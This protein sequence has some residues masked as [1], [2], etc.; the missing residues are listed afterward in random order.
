MHAKVCF[1]TTNFYLSF[2]VCCC[3]SLLQ[4]SISPSTT[5]CPALCVATHCLCFSDLCLHTQHRPSFP[6]CI[7][8]VSLSVCTSWLQLLFSRQSPPILPPACSL[9]GAH[10]CSLVAAV[11]PLCSLPP[12]CC[13]Q[14]SLLLSAASLPSVQHNLPSHT[15][16]LLM[17]AYTDLL[18]PGSCCGF[19][20]TVTAFT[21][22]P[23]FSLLLLLQ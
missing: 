23:C 20:C 21:L 1:L 7:L 16:S 13:R 4:L 15:G 9:R 6:P 2:G 3:F 18:L 12:S 5:S 19:F 10:C 17:L 14:T 8:A 22:H 11:Q